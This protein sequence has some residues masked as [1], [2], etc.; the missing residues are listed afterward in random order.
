MIPTRFMV[1]AGEASGDELAAELVKELRAGI[2]RRV[3]ASNDL[4]PCNS[5][6]APRFFGAGGPRMAEAGVELAFDLTQHSVIGLDLLQKYFQFRKLFHRLFA[7]ALEREPHVIICVD[8]SVFNSMFAAAIKKHVRAR[9]GTF[10]NWEP[11]V[12]KYISPQVWASR[13]GRAYQIARDFD[14][15]LSIFPFEKKWYACRVPS[16]HVEFVGHPLLDRYA[17]AQKNDSNLSPQNPSIV[18]LPGSRQRELE[19]H[20]PI[21][22]E[23]FTKIR[24]AIPFASATV[25]LPSAELSGSARHLISSTPSVQIQTG[26]LPEALRTAT[27]A[28]SKTGTITMEC[29]CFGV[30]TVTLYKTSWATYEIGKRIVK[31]KSLTMPNL[32]AGEP[33]F[34]EFIQNDATP[35]KISAGALE[36]LRN[37][38]ARQHVRARLAEIMTSLGGPGASH[39]AADAI[40]NLL[41]R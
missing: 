25:I 40:L 39:R 5:S 23:A 9:R 29:A 32:L 30:P 16:L 17:F 1:I 28:I 37:E 14:L 18:L 4:Q 35:E 36:L 26:G 19:R 34:P 10:N 22:L 8:F 13:E 3:H 20:L 27:I 41:P 15:L 7:L 38:S 24:A 12:I 6:L 31:V 2:E 33:V 21:M 11:R